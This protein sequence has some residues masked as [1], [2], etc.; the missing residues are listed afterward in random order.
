M[1]RLLNLVTL[2]FFVIFQ[3]TC[4]N[5]QGANRLKKWYSWGNEIEVAKKWY[6]WQD[7]PTLQQQH[8][9]RQNFNPDFSIFS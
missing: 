9:K 1:A 6:D 3:A 2:L 5:V 4:F 7:I 8:Q